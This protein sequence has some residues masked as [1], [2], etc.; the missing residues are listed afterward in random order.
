MDIEKVEA[1]ILLIIDAYEQLVKAIEKRV[2]E[3]E[4]DIVR[5]MQTTSTADDGHSPNHLD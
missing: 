1:E 2:E 4:A 5:E 3:L